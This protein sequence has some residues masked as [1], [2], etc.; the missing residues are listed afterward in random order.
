MKYELNIKYYYLTMNNINL[1]L[2]PKFLPKI[3]SILISDGV[4]KLILARQFIP[5][6]KLELNAYHSRFILHIATKQ[7][8]TQSTHF[9]VNNSSYLYYQHALTSTNSIYFIVIAEP[10]F[11]VIEL[12]KILKSIT[13]FV[14]SVISSN[15]TDITNYDDVRRIIK[16][17][18]CDIVLAIDDM[19]N[20]ILGYEN[21]ST[22][23][24]QQSLKMESQEAKY[25]DKLKEQKIQ[26]AHDELVKGMEEIEYLK[27]NNQYIN[28]HGI[29]NEDVT[30]RELMRK[31][32]ENEMKRL[33][34]RERRQREEIDSIIN[35]TRSLNLHR[36]F[37]SR[38]QSIPNE[39]REQMGAFVG[40]CEN[41]V[42]SIIA[43]ELHR[44]HGTLASFM[45]DDDNDNDDT[46]FQILMPI[47]PM[48]VFFHIN[49]D[50]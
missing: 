32:R 5:I 12:N 49:D 46:E 50:D 2:A 37:M 41:I 15:T 48:R 35:S 34:E 20:P 45:V 27:Y 9:T 21:V 10:T 28:K 25:A 11:N 1:L 23:Q 4:A 33:Q 26:K 38:L 7:H 30:L 29:S 18:A 6:T 43:R 14:L 40:A 17:K 47:M 31:E 22:S 19:V 42:Q 36:H 13:T 8:H 24:L 3:K 39:E 44:Q 16:D